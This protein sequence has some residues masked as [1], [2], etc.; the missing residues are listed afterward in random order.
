MGSNIEFFLHSFLFFCVIFFENFQAQ[1]STHTFQHA[2][3]KYTKTRY[4][5]DL[6]G[7]ER[8]TSINNLPK[9]ERIDEAKAIN[10]SMTALGKV[11]LA[12]K[13]KEK[14]VP[15]RDSVLTRVLRNCFTEKSKTLVIA[16]VTP[17]NYDLNQ[18]MCT[19]DF[20][21]LAGKCV[22]GRGGC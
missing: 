17:F 12:F 15:Y 18:S 11:I 9:Q 20:G 13:R 3:S 5:S 2:I 14:F 10:Q 7:S 8:Q 19:L 6:A 1:T 21:N 4:L 22:L 16:Q